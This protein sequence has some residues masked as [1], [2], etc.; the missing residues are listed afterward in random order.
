MKKTSSGEKMIHV[1][2]VEQNDHVAAGYV[3]NMLGA[4]NGLSV[5]TTD[6]V[7]VDLNNCSVLVLNN[8]PINY[9]LPQDRVVSFIRGGGGILCVHDTLFPSP[10]NQSLLAVAGV[11]LAYDAIKQEKRQDQYVNEFQLARGDPD[12][13]NLRFAVRVVP[14]QTNHPIVAGVEDFEIGDEFWAINIAP[15]VKPL[16]FADVGDRIPC[17]PRFREPITVCGCSGVENG[18]VA[19]LLLGHFRQTYKDVNIAGIIE[20]AVKWLGGQ[21][22]EKEYAFDVFLSFSSENKNEAEKLRS[23]AEA[24]CISVFM[25]ERNLAS[26]D[27]W[28]EAIRKALL[29]SREMAILVSPASLKSE[30]VATEWG[31]AWALQKRITPVLFRCDC[32][33]LPDRLK[34]YEV[35][36]LHETEL[37][38][39]EV[40]SRKGGA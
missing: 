6:S 39:S 15:G 12:D 13:P 20:R 8:L 2:I 21:F 37:Y 34:R 35:R 14:E 1:I 3:G 18:K 38:V 32:A 4:A 22:V 33:Q 16:L 29:A 26:G 36:D 27:V 11:R 31:I 40:L 25:S 17:H 9:E 19:F 7:P 28:D 24:R 5:Y 23:A 30:W 10:Y